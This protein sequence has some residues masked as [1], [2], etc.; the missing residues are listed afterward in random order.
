MIKFKR[1]HWYFVEKL[2]YWVMGSRYDANEKF[3]ILGEV[4]VHIFNLIYPIY[5]LWLS[6]TGQDL[7]F[8]VIIT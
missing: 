3:N 2:N 6:I 1:Y 5:A 4:K 7:A 8:K